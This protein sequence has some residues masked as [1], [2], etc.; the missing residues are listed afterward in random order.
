[1]ETLS[2]DQLRVRLSQYGFPNLPVT[3]TTR[4]VLVKKLQKA[5]EGETTKG[6]RETVAVSKF[7]SD[8]EPEKVEKV[9]APRK[10]KTPNRRATVAVAK[11]EPVINGFSKVVSDAPAPVRRASRNTPA[12]EKASEAPQFVPVL[13]DTDDD[14]PVVQTIKRRSTSRTTTP[15]MGKSETVRTSYATDIKPVEENSGEE[16]YSVDDEEELP[17]PRKPVQ[18]VTR[19]HTSSTMT[20]KVQEQNTPSKFGRATSGTSYTPTYTFPRDDDEDTLE[21][22]APYLS[23][24]ANRLSTIKA[25]PLD[26]GM[27]KYRKNLPP[28][29][30]KAYER[31]SSYNYTRSTPVPKAVA[32]QRGVLAGLSKM[33]DTLD[34]QYNFYTILYVVLIVML[35]V[36]LFVVFM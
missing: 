30:Y 19:R 24:F 5:I 8:E 36:A 1:M 11:S 13:E 17:P 32:N 14:I 6:R 7:S 18:A 28:T 35:I 3:D 25:E 16:I 22:N 29:E 21:L 31:P 10:E 33:F 4:K 27:E 2:D 26:A 12:K 15:T 9:R 23:Q 20:M 34:R